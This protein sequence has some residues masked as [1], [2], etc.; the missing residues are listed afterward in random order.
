VA[1]NGSGSN[2]Q[3]V[4][5]PAGVQRRREFVADGEAGHALCDI[6]GA[7][8]P[9]SSAFSCWW[10]AAGRSLSIACC[11]SA[12]PQGRPQ[13]TERVLEMLGD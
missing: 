4:A 13:I 11:R 9:G 12:G 8:R 5:R 1:R 10:C 7:L 2:D 3:Q 6:D